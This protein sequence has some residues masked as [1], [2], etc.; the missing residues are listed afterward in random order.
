MRRS[1]RKSAAAAT[2]AISSGSKRHHRS[3]VE[4]TKVIKDEPNWER[5]T[6]EI[7]I[8]MPAF[9]PPSPST[10]NSTVTST[11]VKDEPTDEN[12]TVEIP[13]ISSNTSFPSVEV[14]SEDEDELEEEDE[15]AIF[16]PPFIVNLTRIPLYSTSSSSSSSSS[17]AENTASTSGSPTLGASSPVS[18]SSSPSSSSSV[19][20]PQKTATVSGH[21]SPSPDAHVFAV[22]TGIPPHKINGQYHRMSALP[23]APGQ[24]KSGGKPPAISSKSP[25]TVTSSYSPS[26]QMVNPRTYSKAA[27]PAI[28][29]VVPVVT[30]NSSSNL[31]KASTV[32][33]QQQQQQPIQINHSVLTNGNRKITVVKINP[34]GNSSAVATAVESKPILNT[35]VLPNL[36]KVDDK[37]YVFK[38]FIITKSDQQKLKQQQQQQLNKQ[39][40]TVVPVANAL[41]PSQISPSKSSICV[42]NTTNSKNSPPLP[43]AKSP[44]SF[45]NPLSPSFK[46]LKWRKR[47]PNSN[48][49]KSVEGTLELFEKDLFGEKVVVV[50]AEEE[51]AKNA[52]LE[53][54]ESQLD[55]EK[56]EYL[57][58]CNEYLDSEFEVDSDDDVT[59]IDHDKDKD[60]ED[61]DDDQ[62]GL[63]EVAFCRFKQQY[64]PLFAKYI[65]PE[66]LCDCGHCL[67]TFFQDPK[68]VMSDFGVELRRSA[69]TLK[70]LQRERRERRLEKIRT[71]LAAKEAADSGAGN[72]FG[73]AFTE[74]AHTFTIEPQDRPA[75]DSYG[76]SLLQ[77]IAKAQFIKPEED[78]EIRAFKSNLVET[79]VLGTRPTAAQELARL[80]EEERASK[81]LDFTPGGLM[82]NST[83]GNPLLHLKPHSSA[84]R[85]LKDNAAF[86]R[87]RADGLPYKSD[88]HYEYHYQCMYPGCLLTGVNEWN[89]RRHIRTVHLRFPVTKREMEADNLDVVK[90]EREESK[91]IKATCT[92]KKKLK[93][94]EEIQKIEEELLRN[95]EERRA[96]AIQLGQLPMFKD[97]PTSWPPPPLLTSPP[98]KE[99]CVKQEIKEEIF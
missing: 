67:R 60:D 27:K 76:K 71:A 10:V 74:D 26:F 21:P 25:A 47:N 20:S 69:K 14:K 95:M 44:T 72:T 33:Q 45:T 89:M 38:N 24:P 12:T 52:L 49:P 91:Y 15:E 94:P 81:L 2:A 87:R 78:E 32:N 90:V 1:S 40:K 5:D 79:V 59:E 23:A 42:T 4:A 85:R 54:A 36:Q 53:E 86:L 30:S 98:P 61:Y 97:V 8:P 88:I 92:V 18:F 22:P 19:Y 51:A 43:A 80:Q 65:E 75:R 28:I 68:A 31:L 96:R 84:H 46:P 35:D 62:P 64:Q 9:P 37:T 11:I 3:K 50:L 41:K 55:A 13:T 73:T 83:L 93:S 6:E 82:P 66:D 34:G 17:T 99:F 70:R 48:N 56:D 39:H 77:T 63:E 7:P 16:R 58:D 29:P 57:A